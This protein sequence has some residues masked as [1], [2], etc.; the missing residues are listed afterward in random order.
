[1]NKT[2]LKFAYCVAAVSFFTACSTDEGFSPEEAKGYVDGAMSTVDAN[3]D[4]VS[5]D[6][7]GAT[8][9]SVE[10]VSKG[11]VES[12]DKELFETKSS[13]AQYFGL[14]MLAKSKIAP[15]NGG[16]NFLNIDWSGNDVNVNGQMMKNVWSV[17]TAVNADG[18]EAYNMDNVKVGAQYAKKVNGEVIT[19]N[20]TEAD[21]EF[22][23]LYFADAI[24]RYYP[25][26]NYHKYSFYGYYPYYQTMNTNSG[27]DQPKVTKET[28]YV[29]VD[30]DKLDGTQDVIWGSAEPVEGTNEPFNLAYSAKYFRYSQNRDEYDKAIPPTMKFKHKMM[31]LTFSITAGGTPIDYDTDKQHY[32]KAYNTKVKE[33]SITNAPST[34]RLYVASKGTAHSSG[35]LVYNLGTRSTKYILK[36][37]VNGVPDQKWQGVSPQPKKDGDPYK[38]FENQPDTI[39]VGQ[40]IIL[41]ALSNT[42]RE[43]QPYALGLTLEYPKGSGITTSLLVPIRLDQIQN[44]D[45]PFQPGY[46]YNI[47]LK[48][49][50]PEKIELEATCE[51]WK[52][53]DNP[54]FV[55]EDGTIPIH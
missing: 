12:N 2:I 31:M 48:I 17:Y 20:V 10:V 6:L 29:Y 7:S 3:G 33:I 43:K 37:N 51:P 15:D 55:D 42:D 23:R 18:T 46:K 21:A 19:E 45:V 11:A 52:D 49:F 40:G 24:E 13:R 54:F 34:V 22:T 9:G 47:I 32:E 26:G 36:D 38:K 25:I 30:F 53:G 8:K 16:E 27:A 4:R 28:D 39:S 14:F 5:I 35:E 1:M 44:F 41:P 50:A